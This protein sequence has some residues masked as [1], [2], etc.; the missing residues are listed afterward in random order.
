M[1]GL[2]RQTIEYHEASKHHFDRYA[3]GPGYLDWASQ[4]DPFRRYLGA[5]LHRLAVNPPFN[6]PVY[7]IAFDSGHIP[8]IQL[9]VQS[10][11]RLLFDS[12]ALSAWKRAGTERWALRVNPSSGNLHPT[13]GYVIFG[14]MA[15]M[16]ESPLVCHY[17]PKEHGLELRAR[18]PLD[19]WDEL[20]CGLPKES[21]LVG[22][23][24]IHWREA[25]KY[26]ARAYRYC[27]HDIGHAIAAVSLAAAGLGWQARLLDGLSTESLSYLLGVFDPQGA[28]AEEPDC[29]L[30]VYSQNA[31][32]VSPCPLNPDTLAAFRTL[33][34]NGSPNHLSG[35][36]ME[37]PAIDKV[38]SA[39][40]KSPTRESTFEAEDPVP[41][42]R[43]PLLGPELAG[44]PGPKEAR[45]AGLRQIIHQRRSAVA[46]DGVASIPRSSFFE[47]L[48]RTMPVPRRIPFMTL[49]WEAH[50]HLALFV[51]RVDGLAPGLYFLLRNVREKDELRSAMRGSFVWKKPDYCPDALELY[52]LAEGDV[53]KAAMQI[54]CFQEIAGDGCFSVAMIAA[55]EGPLNRYGPWFYPRLFW[56]CGMIGQVL[57]LEAEVAGVRATGIGCFFDDPTHEVLGLKGRSYQDLYHFTVGGPIE[58]HRLTTLP[59]YPL[60]R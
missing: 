23:T 40:R 41:N 59:P 16:D 37:W 48:L 28:E 2:V 55:F 27:R 15:G 58:D 33:S 44:G 26:G 25:W 19:L 42:V 49:P 39:S 29:L 1:E 51:H 52:L 13:E 60:E 4:P 21:V 45:M 14:P 11:S 6:D 17:A 8:S 20:I 56:E 43:E 10:L 36:H 35:T 57:Y 12:L 24:S 34:W 3:R 32:P 22:L 50:T 9:D 18:F 5:P 47:M 31:P 46:M 38:A 54:S 53:R 30:A 7:D